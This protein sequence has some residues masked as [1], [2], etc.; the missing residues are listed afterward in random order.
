MSA[1]R[2]KCYPCPETCGTDK[3]ADCPIVKKGAFDDF[4]TQLQSDEH[5]IDPY[6]PVVKGKVTDKEIP[7]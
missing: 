2:K 5:P 6:E 7:F 4:D 3:P 1:P